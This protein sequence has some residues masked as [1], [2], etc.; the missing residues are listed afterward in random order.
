MTW[1]CQLSEGKLFTHLSVITSQ[2]SSFFLP[3]LYILRAFLM[4]LRRIFFFFQTLI[5]CLLSLI[6]FCGYWYI[7]RSIC[8]ALDQKLCLTVLS[9]QCNHQLLGKAHKIGKNIFLVCF[10]NSYGICLREF[11]QN[12]SS[13]MCWNSSHILPFSIASRTDSNLYA[14]LEA[15]E[16]LSER[17]QEH[18]NV[19]PILLLQ[20]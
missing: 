4:C 20:R 10:L 2:L 15:K 8:I 9:Q 12:T 3:H 6:V 19:N 14:L 18:E 7:C 16:L 5:S 17:A 11:V 13:V 1:V